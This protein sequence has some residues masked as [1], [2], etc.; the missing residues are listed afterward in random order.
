MKAVRPKSHRELMESW[1]L[2]A[3]ERYNQITS[4]D[5]LSFHHVVAPTALSLLDG[6][7]TTKVLDIGS[8]I[9]QFTLQLAARSGQVLAVEP[10]RVSVH[11]A[12]ATCAPKGNVHFIESYL[13]HVTE[14]LSGSG[15]TS[16]VAVMSLMTA[17]NLQDVAQSIRAI[18]PLNAKFIAVLTHPWFWPH[19]WKYY[20]KNWFRYQKE[21][22]IEAQFSISTR[23]TEV[24]TTHIHRPLE[25]YLSAFSEN[26]FYLETIVEPIPSREVQELYPKPWRFPRFIGLKWVK[27]TT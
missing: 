12:R 6:S 27:C 26:G 11:L 25:Q 15:V 18:L 17:P 14:D 22:F 20:N 4:G 16:A 8:G 3:M 1:D 2:L 13:E 9:G 23:S 21:T 24:M 19:Y 5:D 10:S 7:D